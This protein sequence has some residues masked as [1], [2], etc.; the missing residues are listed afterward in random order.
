MHI[1]DSA[2]DESPQ[3]KQLKQSISSLERQITDVT[4][5]IDHAKQAVYT[6]EQSYEKK[7][8]P[9][10]SIVNDLDRALQK[11]QSLRDNVDEFFSF[12]E[13][14]KLFDEMMADRQRE[15]A[16]ARART[17]TQQ[18]TEV[19]SE[20]LTPADRKK[21]KLVYRR[22]ARLYHPD[23]IGGDAS[24]MI[25]INSAYDRGDI[26]ALV[27]I[28]RT[29]LPHHVDLSST[30]G[31]LSKVAYLQH[32][33]SDLK[34]TLRTIRRSEMYKMRERMAKSHTSFDVGLDEL[35]C[36]MEKEIAYKKTQIAILKDAFDAMNETVV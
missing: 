34:K 19:W 23:I 18:K 26:E 1:N 29:H 24:L 36:A 20:L 17:S 25:V 21:M 2:I 15:Q 31:L 10:V 27:E 13:A 22:L 3:K 16:E 33:F 28:E 7:I 30:R 8:G 9:L 6:F 4:E 32:C 14:S 5:Q 35:A 12:D 11:Y